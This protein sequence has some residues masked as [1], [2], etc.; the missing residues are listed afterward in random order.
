VVSW[1]LAVV[2]PDGSGLR[3]LGEGREP[4]WAPDSRSLYVRRGDA[5]VHVPLETPAGAA[6][7][8]GTE[9]GGSPAVSPDGKWLAFT[10]RDPGSTGLDL[11]VKRLTP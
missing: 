3:L 4:A 1:R 9:R 5:I 2:R 8:P 11:W 10:R 6:P 7:V